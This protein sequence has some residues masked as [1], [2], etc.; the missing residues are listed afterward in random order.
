M[1]VLINSDI[2]YSGRLVTDT[3]TLRVRELIDACRDLGHR[4]VLPETAKLEWDRQ[5]ADHVQKA[6]S[7][8]GN[9]YK[10]LEHHGVEFA[11]CRPD[12]IIVPPDLIKLIEASGVDVRIE[13]P[14][15][16]DLVDAHNR[17]CLH[18]P[19]QPPDAESDEMRDLVIWAI[20]IRV[21]RTSGGALLVSADKVH[22]HDR[23]NEEASSAGL[24]RAKST[25]DALEI[26]HVGT[27]SGRLFSSL[28][29][30]AW[31]GLR[32]AG[33]PVGSNPRLA[34]VL[35]AS[36]VQGSDGSPELASADITIA[37]D[38]SA[39]ISG[40]AEVRPVLDDRQ[41]VLLTELTDGADRLPPYVAESHSALKSAQ[42][43]D[44]P[45]RLSYLTEF[46]G[47]DH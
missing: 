4:L 28:L 6:R 30:P 37:S 1:D 39:P 33:L 31:D 46:L 40:H 21:A 34:R 8:L 44:Y 14:T 24:T 27:P 23:G 15:L 5:Q 3:L 25:E 47:G 32:A 42:F 9:A 18:L 20:A 45:D 26:L 29:A 16:D 7:A 22:T 41:V 12:D 10:T 11:D 36:L 2:L 43:S 19:P 13:A 38:G 17:A 35:A